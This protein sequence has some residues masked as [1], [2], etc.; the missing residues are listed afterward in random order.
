MM[1]TPCFFGVDGE[2]RV[3]DSRGEAPPMPALGTILKTESLFRRHADEVLDFYGQT[4][5]STTA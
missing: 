1:G 5:G 2:G 4:K 3:N